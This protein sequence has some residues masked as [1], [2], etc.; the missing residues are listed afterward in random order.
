MRQM[1]IFDYKPR[2]KPYE[3]SWNRYIGQKVCDIYG[4][5][6]TVKSIEPYYTICTDGVRDYAGTSTTIYPVEE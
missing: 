1:N 2:L 6:L 4:R 5:L 3:Y